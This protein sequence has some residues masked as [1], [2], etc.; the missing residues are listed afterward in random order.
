MNGS[1]S[2]VKPIPNSQ[3]LTEVSETKITATFSGP[4]PPPNILAG[5]DQVLPG[6]ADRIITMAEKQLVHRQSL[7][8]VIVHS[9]ISH[10]KLGMW[11]AFIITCALVLFGAYLISQGKEVAGY[12]AVFVP[13]FF[14]AG[15]YIWAKRED[16]SDGAPKSKDGSIS[17]I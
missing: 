15:S 8:T 14:N 4:L 13:I 7:E 11:F 9:N 6:A 1:I 3:P 17:S 16:K 10:E 2:Q 5:Y 12:I